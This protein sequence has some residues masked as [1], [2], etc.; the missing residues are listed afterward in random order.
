MR[1]GLRGFPFVG[2]PRESYRLG[3]IALRRCRSALRATREDNASS[4]RDSFFFR[5]CP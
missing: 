3:G 4:A 1:E 2:G 5:M